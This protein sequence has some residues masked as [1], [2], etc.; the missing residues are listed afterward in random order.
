[1]FDVVVR[2]AKE[3]GVPAVRC[4]TEPRPPLRN[5]VRT[6]NNVSGK[7]VRQYV[8]ARALSAF[9]LANRTKLE[10]AGLRSP[11]ALLGVTETGYVNSQTLR[12]M[13]A[14]LSDGVTELMC[15]PGYADEHLRAWRTR[16]VESREVEAEA[17]TDREVRALLE[18]EGIHLMTYREL[19]E[20]DEK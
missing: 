5:R 16:L 11:R 8:V 2:L 9:A 3:F 14:G 12:A 19:A 7:I 6:S 1:M 18:R 20:Y 10:R 4:A 13:L 15:H 17:L